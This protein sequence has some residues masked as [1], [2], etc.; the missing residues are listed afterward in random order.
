MTAIEQSIY[1]LVRK[2]YQKSI[3]NNFENYLNRE[4]GYCDIKREIEHIS[5]E[6]H[7]LLKL[8]PLVWKNVKDGKIYTLANRTLDDM[9][10]RA[11]KLCK[12]LII[13]S[14]K[15]ERAQ[16]PCKYERG[17]SDEN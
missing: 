14:A 16:N 8:E 13:L 12:I 2:E 10:N 11:L 1:E 15:I 5:L 17:F 6:Y 4:E 7:E 3:I 9:Q